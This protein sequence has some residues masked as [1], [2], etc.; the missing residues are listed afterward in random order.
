MTSCL[1]RFYLLK[2]KLECSIFTAEYSREFSVEIVQEISFQCFLGCF[3]RVAV[4]KRGTVWGCNC[5]STIDHC[6]LNC[7]NVKY[8]ETVKC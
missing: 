7:G 8:I 3:I 1:G 5:A 6:G 2:R 4:C